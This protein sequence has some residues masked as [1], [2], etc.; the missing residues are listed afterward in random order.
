MI[1]MIVEPDYNEVM[2]Y[3]KKGRIC[4]SK[5]SD[6]RMSWFF[7]RKWVAATFVIS[8]LSLIGASMY[9][10]DSNFFWYEINGSWY[11]VLAAGGFVGSALYLVGTTHAMRPRSYLTAMV[12]DLSDAISKFAG[13]SHNGVPNVERYFFAEKHLYEC[14]EEF[15]ELARSYPVAAET[16]PQ[17]KTETEERLRFR[18]QL[19]LQ[20]NNLTRFSDPQD[21]GAFK[22]N[23]YVAIREMND[24]T[25]HIAKL[26]NA[27]RGRESLVFRVP[28]I[29]RISVAAEAYIE[30]KTEVE[31]IAS[32][33]LADTT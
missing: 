12:D 10:T 19:L 6:S 14:L 5:Y 28:E 2:R 21:L 1:D 23:V 30:A 26:M 13:G 20:A 29:S 9:P 7:G 8:V 31:T 16:Y 22:E 3:D 33:H 15:L 27:I 4:K 11:Y 17:I 32:T 24:Y 25:E 18:D